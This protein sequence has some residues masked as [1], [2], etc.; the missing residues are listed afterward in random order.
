YY[1]TQALRRT[2]GPHALR[3]FPSL[4][5]AAECVHERSV[6]GTLPTLAR[7][8]LLHAANGSPYPLLNHL[9]SRFDVFHASHQLLRPPRN[10][11]VTATLYDLTC[12]LVPR[13]HSASNVAMARKFAQR[14][15]QRAAGIIAISENTRDDA[16]RVLGL[17]G[18][19]I[20]V[21]YPGVAEAFFTA[22]PARRRKPYVLF[23]GTIEPRKNVAAIL[24]AWALLPAA[25]REEYDLVV[26]GSPG[27]GDPT[28]MARLRSGLPGVHYLGYVPEEELPALTRGAAAF[29]YPSLYE[30]F[31]LPVAQAM[32]AQVPVVT[33]NLSC[34]PEV[35]GPGG[36]FVDPR[37]PGE[38]RDALHS[39]L[40]SASLRQQLGAAGARRAA[41]YHWDTCAQQSWRFFQSV[42]GG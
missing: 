14:V 11:C 23:V 19:R 32:A 18:R 26:A 29:V 15:L 9:G 2:A 30:G 16:V 21:I 28:V 33:S 8:A 22:A 20:A 24:D 10:T 38:L 13:L 7:L 37:S 41:L 36:L 12:W 1:W 35:A 3:L 6:L 27:W 40:G 42:A 17:D 31:G 4:D 5:Q 39:L 25:R 34:L